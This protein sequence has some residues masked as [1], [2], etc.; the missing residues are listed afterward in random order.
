MTPTT[1]L[2]VPVP[3]ADAAIDRLRRRLDPTHR[4]GMLAHVTILVPFVPPRELGSRT[5]TELAGLFDTVPPFEFC[6]QRTR[7]FDD[8]VLYLEPE[9]AEPFRRLTL[10]VAARFPDYPP[11]EG[12]FPD[13]VP[14]VTV[15]EG[16]RVRRRRWRMRRA[17]AHLAGMSPI[18]TTASEVWLMEL[19]PVRSAWRQ[20]E[21]FLLGSH[22]RQGDRTS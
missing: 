15:G 8:R 14:H 13:V 10:A 22:D 2:L 20:R 19:D 9:P 21:R 7:W 6:L 3:A 4:Q 11:Y 18:R 17:A 16:G 5:S 12:A 1:I